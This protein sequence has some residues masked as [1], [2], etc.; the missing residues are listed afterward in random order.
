MLHAIVN[1]LENSVHHKS[2]KYIGNSG[3]L[4]QYTGAFIASKKYPVSEKHLD[5]QNE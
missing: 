1:L 5:T 2:G 4:P 3:L